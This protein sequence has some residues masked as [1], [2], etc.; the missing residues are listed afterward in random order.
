MSQSVAFVSVRSEI[1]SIDLDLMKIW[2]INMYVVDHETVLEQWWCIA[3][4]MNENPKSGKLINL[5]RHFDTSWCAILFRN[6]IVNNSLISLFCY[7]STISWKDFA[8]FK[9][10]KLKFWLFAWSRYLIVFKV[11]SCY[12]QR[13]HCPQWLT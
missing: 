9:L 12:T 1:I 10:W 13:I 4:L 3:S 7:Y 8:V 6:L 2:W 11:L 5:A